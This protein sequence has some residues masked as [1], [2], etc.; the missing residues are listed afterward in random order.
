MF[1]LIL[2]QIKKEGYAFNNIIFLISSSWETIGWFIALAQKCIRVSS[3]IYVIAECHVTLD[4]MGI[5]FLN[6][7][8]WMFSKWENPVIFSGV[9]YLKVKTE[10]LS[11]YSFRSIHEN[12]LLCLWV[13]LYLLAQFTIFIIF[14]LTHWW[15]VVST[16]W[17]RHQVDTCFNTFK[18]QF[19]STIFG[20][21]L[22]SNN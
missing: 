19:L 6:P 21:W 5:Y 7:R 16:V 15:L 10:P 2:E 12:S 20:C 3:T 1:S 13:L 4:L 9:R 17:R 8:Q 14:I 22:R 11:K 18:Q